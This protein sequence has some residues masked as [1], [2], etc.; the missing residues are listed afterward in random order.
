MNDPIHD[1]SQGFDDFCKQIRQLKENEETLASL[2]EEMTTYEEVAM[3]LAVQPSE[4]SDIEEEEEDDSSTTR[5]QLVEQMMHKDIEDL[6][7]KV[8]ELVRP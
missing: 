2:R 1:T 7:M 5:C 8:N 6:K 3:W 4:A